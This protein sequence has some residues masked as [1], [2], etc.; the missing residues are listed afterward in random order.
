VSFA[1]HK[2]RPF[3]A[4]TA[5]D[6]PVEA[7]VYFVSCMVSDERVVGAMAADSLLG[8]QATCQPMNPLG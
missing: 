3:L 1:S 7:G 5:S 4:G 8:R 2:E 6:G